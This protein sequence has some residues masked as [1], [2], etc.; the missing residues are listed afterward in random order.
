MGQGL[1]S[2]IPTYKII[3]FVSHNKTG[4]SLMN[5]STNSYLGNAAFPTSSHNNKHFAYLLE[6]VSQIH[7]L[8]HRWGGSRYKTEFCNL[9]THTQRRQFCPGLKNFLGRRNFRD[10]T[11]SLRQTRLFQ[12]SFDSVPKS[13]ALKTMERL[14]EIPF[15]VWFSSSVLRLSSGKLRAHSLQGESH[16]TDPRL[17]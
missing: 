5:N 11:G 2:I 10:K 15:T 1:P 17:L 12:E 9:H 4:L 16:P 6:V 14:L 7:F 3:T 13:P 8:S